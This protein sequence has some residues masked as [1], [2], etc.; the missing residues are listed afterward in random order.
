MSTFDEVIQNISEQMRL[1]FVGA[2]K[3]YGTPEDIGANREKVVRDFLKSYF[4]PN[5]QLGKGEII[6]SNTVRSGQIDVVV[7]TPSHPFTISQ[8]DAR[9]LFFAEGVACAI[10]VK[11]DLSDA[12]ELERGLRQIWKVKKLE[13][14][15]IRGDV[16]FG[17]KYDQERLKRIPAVL[18][19]YKSP[20]IPTLKAN[21][22]KIHRKLRIP[23]K[24]QADAVVVL[25]RGIIY[26][27]KDSRDRLM[28][29]V[30][31]ERK[32][33]LVGF[34][35]GKRTLVRFLLLLSQLI[36]WRIRMIPIIH[37]YTGALSMESGKVF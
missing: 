3:I 19:S 15:P 10:D 7:C 5:Y 27:V 26:N 20:T 25:D 23:T 4:P 11:S 31:G 6:D 14:K 34:G 24:E 22:I 36:P 9:G 18:F 32:L 2:S 17:S 13:C 1:A 8:Q 37:L 33:G 28:I 21:I 30:K 29:A 16:M 35:H 12:K